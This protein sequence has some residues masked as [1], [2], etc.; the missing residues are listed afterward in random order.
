MRIEGA[1]VSWRNVWA[2]NEKAPALTDR[3]Q[4]D[5][6]FGGGLVSKWVRL[7]LDVLRG[8]HHAT[9]KLGAAHFFQFSLE[10][11]ELIALAPCGL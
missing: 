3:C 1:G 5:S 7:R 6:R 8:K 9:I 4:I 11:A 2:G 10:V